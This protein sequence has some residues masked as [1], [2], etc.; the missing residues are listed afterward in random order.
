MSND[1]PNMHGV[2][3]HIRLC[4]TARQ[5]L[6]TKKNPKITISGIQIVSKGNP[7]PL[8]IPPLVRPVQLTRAHSRRG[9]A[10]IPRGALALVCRMPPNRSTSLRCN[11]LHEADDTGV[12]GCYTNT[13]GSRPAIQRMTVHPATQ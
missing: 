4:G 3:L 10:A 5:S 12:D 9:R 6:P 11:I 2:V 7:S 13:R 8:S 1:I